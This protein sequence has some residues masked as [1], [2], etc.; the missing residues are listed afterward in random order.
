MVLITIENGI[1]QTVP[2]NTAV[3]NKTNIYVIAGFNFP[4]K[5]KKHRIT[6]GKTPKKTDSP[7]GAIGV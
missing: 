2:A 4:V 7:I 1:P 6:N 3:N 5:S